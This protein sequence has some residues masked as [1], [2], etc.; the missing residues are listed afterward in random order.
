MFLEVLS[1][2]A[3]EL[4]SFLGISQF[5]VC[6]EDLIF[7]STNHDFF[8]A[9]LQR[10]VSLPNLTQA[11]SCCAGSEKDRKLFQAHNIQIAAEQK[12]GSVRL[13]SQN[14]LHK[15]WWMM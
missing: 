9:K 13:V 12:E 1:L 6:S 14:H 15:Q 3:A 8:V 7:H 4:R 11:L 10:D 2:P 5:A